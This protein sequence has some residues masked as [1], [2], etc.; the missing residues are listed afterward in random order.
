MT[1]SNSETSKLWTPANKVTLARILLIPLFVVAI[2]SPWPQW[3]FPENAFILQAKGIIAA[4]IFVFIS[5]TDAV[6]GYLARSR[7]E[8]TNLGKFMDPLADKILVAA[9][10]L[11]LIE[12]QVLPSWVALVILAREFIISGVRMMAAADGVVIAASWYGKIKT[13]TQ[14]IAVVL[15]LIK[16]SPLLTGIDPGFAKA[17]YIISWLAMFVALFFTIVSMIDYLYKSRSLFT[18]KPVVAHHVASNYKVDAP[19]DAELAVMAEQVLQTAKDAGKTL[20]TA[21]SCTGGYIAQCLTAIPGSSECFKGAVVSYVNA[22]KTSVLGVSSQTIKKHTEVSEEA[23]CEMARGVRY[24][25][26]CDVG[27]SVTGVAGPGG[28]TEEHPVGT[29][30]LGVSTD[31]ET[32]AIECH[33]PGDRDE[34]RRQAVMKA[35]DLL[36]QGAQGLQP[37]ESEQVPKSAD[38]ATSLAE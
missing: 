3:L 5:C 36:M 19:S 21:E 26:R 34:V 32:R 14:I 38:E 12:L 18:G 35:L 13:V 17:L 31:S 24:Q 9:A 30:F 15:F 37:E 29:V 25:L 22:V 2:L 23:A 4:L 11:A 16:D 6:D 7:N 1:Q 10:L 8:V 33:F 28:G 27:V 20:G